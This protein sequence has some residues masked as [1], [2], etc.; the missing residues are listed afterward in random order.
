[1]IKGKTV[2]ITG[3]AGFI[4]SNIAGRLVEDNRVVI[5]DNL[6]RN[7]IK[8]KPYKDHPN[9][10]LVEGS[11]LD[12]PSLTKAM[13]GANIVVHC[14]AVA[15]VDSVINNPLNTMNVNVIGSANV[16]EAASKL[17]DCQHVSCFSTSEI[18]GQYSFRSAEEANAVIG[19]LGD[20]RWTY[21]TSKLTSEHLA[22]SYFK[23]M[24]LPTTI[25][26]PFNVYGAGQVGEGAI[27]HFVQW[28]IKDEPIVIHGDG[29]Q[30][31]SWCYVDDMVDAVL[32]TM[33]EPKSAG[34]SFNIGN[35]RTVTTVYNLAETIIRVTGS[36]SQITFIPK[37]YSDVE[38]RIPSIRK[39][40]GMLGFEP[41]IDL[42]EGIQRT[43]EYFRGRM[44]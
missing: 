41:K 16:L 2:F 39:A 5:F 28:A 6:A 8:D 19:G 21:A 42:D 43:A 32:L 14:A 44:A 17:V 9:L 4:G 22:I 30:I 10:T 33:A 35:E 34:E 13:D 38:L 36:K 7:S 31:R 1:V 26:R 23:Q 12:V 40:H 18:F 27:F 20:P 24:G 29:T 37:D 25:L 15:G 3:G 11:I